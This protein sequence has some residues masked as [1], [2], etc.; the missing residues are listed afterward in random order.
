[1]IREAAQSNSDAEGDTVDQPA[2][3]GAKR[4]KTKSNISRG[5]NFKTVEVRTLLDILEKALPLGGYHWS[6]VTEDF[7]KAMKQ[8]GISSV[9]RSLE[10]LR[11]KFKALKNSPKPTGDHPTC[12]EEVRRAKR[13]NREVGVQHRICISLI[14]F[15]WKRKWNALISMMMTSI[16]KKMW[17]R[18]STSSVSLD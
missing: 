15:R 4:P 13:I 14:G 18:N 16:T 1:M 17:K 9:E 8:L 5:G 12:P 7:N 2:R 11:G 6:K 3:N 10:S